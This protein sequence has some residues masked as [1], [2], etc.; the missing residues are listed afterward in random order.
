MQSARFR[1]TIPSLLLLVDH[2]HEGILATTYVLQEPGYRI[3]TARSAEDALAPMKEQQLEL[4]ITDFKMAQMDG[5][6]LIATLRNSGYNQPVIL[7]SGVVETL[8][9]NTTDTGASLVIQKSKN[10]VDQLVRGIQ[11]LLTRTQ[12]TRIDACVS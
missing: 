9:L 2:N 3:L 5:V 11:R 1:A 12:T 10:E 8:G 7:R 6:G 4:G